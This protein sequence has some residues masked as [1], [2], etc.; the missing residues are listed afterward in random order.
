MKKLTYAILIILALSI[1]QTS[2][3][4]CKCGKK[5]TPEQSMNDPKT[6][7]IFVGIPLESKIEGEYDIYNFVVKKV[8]KGTTG[9]DYVDIRTK[10]NANKCGFPFAMDFEHLVY[11]YKADG[12]FTTDSCTRTSLF[13]DASVD[14]KA[15]NITINS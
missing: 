14:I 2:S 9:G 7:L 5:P 4:Q 10:T 1:I 6:E 8:V 13:K 15:F 11:A 12:A 3:Q